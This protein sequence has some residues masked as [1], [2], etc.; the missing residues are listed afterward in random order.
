MTA[1][2]KFTPFL[3]L[4]SLSAGAQRKHVGASPSDSSCGGS[5][6]LAALSRGAGSSLLSAYGYDLREP[7]A[8]SKVESSWAVGATILHF[9][10]ITVQT[11]DQTAFSVVRVP[12]LEYIWVIPI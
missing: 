7:W 1:K 11:D 3:L 6:L 8:C 2:Q 4:L 12:G 9:R 10:K 5:P